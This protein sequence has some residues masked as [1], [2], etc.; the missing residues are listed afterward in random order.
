M[1]PYLHLTCL[2]GRESL[3]P[4]AE[5]E[6]FLFRGPHLFERESIGLNGVDRKR[7]G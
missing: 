4:L 7:C 1:N 2:P 5:R 3:G 6:F